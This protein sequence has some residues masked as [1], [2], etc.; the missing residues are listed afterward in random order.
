MKCGGKG[1]EISGY[2]YKDVPGPG[3]PE[4]SQ[5]HKSSKHVE[6]LRRKRNKSESFIIIFL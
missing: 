2:R 4:N 3:V 5:V 6:N 1:K